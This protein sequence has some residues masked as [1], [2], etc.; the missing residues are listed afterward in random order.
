MAA[1]AVALLIASL[2]AYPAYQLI[3]PW[4]PE[5]RLD[6]IASRLFDL[7]LLGFIILVLQRLRLK[8][9][10]AW[11]WQTQAGLGARQYLVGAALG[12]L[13]MSCVSVSM[14]LLGARSLDSSLDA[15]MLLTAL[16]AGLGSGLV[17]GLVEETLFR[18]LILG[19]A[20]RDS[21]SAWPGLIA[22]SILFASLHFL[23]NVK[24]AHEDVTPWSGWLLLTS[25]FADFMHPE[26]LIDA[27]LALFGVGLLTGLARITTGNVLFAAGLHG[28]WVLVMRTTIGITQLP[29]DAANAW[30]LSNHDGYT[31]WLVTFFILLFLAA[32][33]LA[34]RPLRA[35]LRIT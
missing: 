22:V 15:A 19:A 11:G 20:T 16:Q 29:K 33:K 21:R 4:Q 34:S 31:G 1:I 10:E 18:G 25:T 13:T 14:V 3:H 5:W 7:V 28:G 23:A 27:F 6:K 35:L 30:L 32:A 8:G 24:I 17:V 2:L 12:I 26:R 9:R